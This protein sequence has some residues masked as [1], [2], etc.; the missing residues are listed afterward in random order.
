MTLAGLCPPLGEQA[1]KLK[2]WLEFTSA[3]G[4]NFRADFLK[5]AAEAGFAPSAFE[6]FWEWLYAPPAVVDPDRLAGLGWGFLTDYYLAA[7][8][9]RHYA[10]VEMDAGGPPLAPGFTDRVLPLSARDLEEAMTRS[11]ADCRHLPLMAALASL[12]ILLAAFKN[13]AEALAAFLPALAGLTAVLTV[14]LFSGRALGLAAAAALPLVIGLGADYGL[15]AVS[16][17]RRKGSL[18]AG[19]A[20]LVAGLSTMIGMGLLALTRHPVLRALGETISVGLLAAMPV[21]ILGL[22]RLFAARAEKEGLV[23]RRV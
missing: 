3:L 15:V 9:G 20:I 10:L 12:A 1:E 22:P 11:L 6:P 18:G 16:E 21:A 4:E 7:R 2:G 17:A 19:R 5:T 14:N 13:K 8:D 23:C